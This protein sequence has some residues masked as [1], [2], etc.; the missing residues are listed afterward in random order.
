MTP[1]PKPAARY[2]ATANE[3]K[4]IFEHFDN[5]PCVAC[6]LRPASLHHIV[7]KSQRGDDLITNLV[8]LCGNGTTGC[9]GRLEA[10]SD[11]WEIIAARVRLYVTEKES[12]R[13]YVLDKIGQDRF[14]RRYP[15]AVSLADVALF[16]RP[17]MKLRALNEREQ[18]ALSEPDDGGGISRPL[19][20]RLATDTDPGLGTGASGSESVDLN[21]LTP[22]Q[23]ASLLKSI[24]TDA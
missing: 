11:G 9:H 4:R 21:N 18:A 24:E 5:E 22:Q 10:H 16:A 23:Q 20:R 8:P 3:W 15:R 2:V 7:P 19:G 6:G 14:D 17:N 12:R 13:R 1:D